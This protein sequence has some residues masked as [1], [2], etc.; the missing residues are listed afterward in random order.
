MSQFE[1]G[2]ANPRWRGGERMVSD[3]GYVKVRVGVDHPLADPH[4]YTYEHLLVWIAAGN[5]PPK[6]D[7]TLHHASGDKTDNRIEN[8]RLLLV[9]EHSRMHAATQPRLRGRFARV[10]VGATP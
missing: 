1:P 2:S 8:L 7:E 3:H 6:G 10:E 5:P 9:S 4:G